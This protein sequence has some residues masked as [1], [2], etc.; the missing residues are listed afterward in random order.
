MVGDDLIFSHVSHVTCFAPEDDRF[1]CQSELSLVLWSS[2]RMGPRHTMI[3]EHSTWDILSLVFLKTTC[4]DPLQIRPSFCIMRSTYIY[5]LGNS[6]Y[7]YS[8]SW[9]SSKAQI[10]QGKCQNCSGFN[11]LVV[12]SNDLQIINIKT[13]YDVILFVF[14]V[15][16]FATLIYFKTFDIVKHFMSLFLLREGR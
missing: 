15:D 13:Q 6:I 4:S 11:L 2:Q 8:K 12:T 10:F 16:T 1:Q 9:F 14:H 5:S 7:L 3:L